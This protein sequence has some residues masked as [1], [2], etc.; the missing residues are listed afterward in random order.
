MVSLDIFHQDPFKTIQLTTA[1]EKVPYLPDGL[2]AMGIFEDKPIRT[3][4]LMVEERDGK[5][6]IIPFSDRGSPATERTTERRKARYFEVPRLRHGDTVYADEVAAIR[7]FGQETVLMQV[8]TEL[9]RRMVG[10]TGLRQ[11]L[12]Y[13]QEYHRLA[14]VQGLLLD[15][16]GSVKYNWYNEFGI[17][18]N[19]TVAFNLIANTARTI[20]PLAAGIVRTMKRKAQGA[21]IE[22]RS[23]V[24]ALCGDAFYDNFVTHTDVEKTYANWLQ[25]ASLR[26]GTAYK[27][28]DFADV[29]WI[30]YRGSDD[31]SLI[32]AG[33]TNGSAAI[34]GLPT[35]LAN[36]QDI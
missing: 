26:E 15:Y 5:L 13:T 22:N 36:G 20:R 1:I 24:I 28:F 2:E 16:D 34:T 12:R 7:E 17:T 6:V 30:N 10:P 33:F 29:T 14:A 27:Q 35:G 21:F 4:A 31:T 32:S 18:P 25:A 8:Q 3:K 11:N 23:K 19:P 9:A